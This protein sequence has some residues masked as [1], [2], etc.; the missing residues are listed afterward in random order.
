MIDIKKLI[1]DLQATA[2]TSAAPINVTINITSGDVA[3]VVAPA[4]ETPDTDFEVGDRVFVC[5]IRKDGTGTKHTIGTVDAV[6]QQDDKGWY[7]R[8]TGDNGCHYRTGLKID[9]ERLGSKV[10]MMVED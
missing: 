9:E 8:V 2:K 6:L 1:A 7:T 3:D 10:I 5:H 4:V